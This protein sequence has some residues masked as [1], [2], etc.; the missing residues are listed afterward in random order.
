MVWV[1]N[2]EDG[3]NVYASTQSTAS[4]RATANGWA[5]DQLDGW[6]YAYYGLNNDGTFDP[7]YNPTGSNNNATTL[8]DKPGGWPNNTLF[9]ALDVA[10]CYTS[11]ACQNC[12]LGYYFWSWSIDNN[13][14]STQFIAAP[15][16]KD[17]D[18]EFQD[19]VTGWNNWAPKS[20][21]E[22]EGGGQPK[23]PNAVQLP[24][25]TDL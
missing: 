8:F 11:R 1:F 25:L 7:G 6:A 17:L 10:V 18:K 13:G 5:I 19:A 9:Y 20:G 21:P 16:W 12:I 14:T 22:D 24:T 23:L 15:A 2:E 4:A 3:T